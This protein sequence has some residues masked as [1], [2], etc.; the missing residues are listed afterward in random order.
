[1]GK[2]LMSLVL[3]LLCVIFCSCGKTASTLE[4]CF[5]CVYSIVCSDEARYD[6]IGS[7][8]I[9][10]ENKVITNAHVV[11]YLDD[12]ERVLYNT[13]IAKSYN[14]D[15]E[16]FL[17][18]DIV[19]YEKDFAVLSFTNNEDRINKYLQTGS[20]DSLKIGDPLKTI[21]NLNNYGLSCNKG[22]LSSYKKRILHNSVYNEYY[23]T[24]IE[25]S[26]GSSGGP[27][28]NKKNEVVGI[29]TFKVRDNNAEY[30][31]GMSFFIPIETVLKSFS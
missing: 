20:S 6:S 28:L 15:K 8:F 24:D 7:A 19:D 27:V 23:Q 10:K 5:N 31:D 18:V 26:K 21:G 17:S 29:M 2:R 14:S 9:I 1:M 11:S 3:S 25:I 13:I 12:N 16:I 30:V 4:E 22:I